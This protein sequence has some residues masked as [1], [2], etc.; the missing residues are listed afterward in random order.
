MHIFTEN[1]EGLDQAR[2]SGSVGERITVK[3]KPVRVA[4]ESEYHAALKEVNRCNSTA[5]RKAARNVSQLYDAALSDSGLRSTQRSIL[6]HIARAGRPLMG[7]LAEK[8]V[9]DRTALSHNL[10]PL[11]RDGLVLVV[12]D[13]LDKRSR[14]I[15]LTKAGKQKIRETLCLWENAQQVFERSFGVK[16]ARELRDALAIIASLK[17]DNPPDFSG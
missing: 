5:L 4:T 7:E 9:L 13:D 16:R 3:D 12:V 15:V 14:R 10:K 2:L 17:F 11:E 1:A 8:L 6:L